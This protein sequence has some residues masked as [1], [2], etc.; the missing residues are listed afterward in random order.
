MIYVLRDKIEHKFIKKKTIMMLAMMSICIWNLKIVHHHHVRELKW[1][2]LLTCLLWRAGRVISFLLQCN[3]F[4][5]ETGSGCF[6]QNALIINNELATKIHQAM[7]RH[8]EKVILPLKKSC[9]MDGMS[10]VMM[11][12]QL[13][14][15]IH[16]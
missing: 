16:S 4:F 9:S 13:V 10:I 12:G 2:M 6:E 11:V 15:R 8:L 5:N 14:R 3:F 1:V 7:E